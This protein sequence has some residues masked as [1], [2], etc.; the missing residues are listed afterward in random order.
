MPKYNYPFIKPSTIKGLGGYS[1]N[2]QAP[3]SDL[4]D[5]GITSTTVNISINSLFRSEPSKDNIPFEYLGKTY[6][7]NK[8]ALE[9]YD[10]TLISTAKRNIEVSAILLVGKAEQSPDKTIGEILQHP[11]CDPAVRAG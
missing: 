3:I 5:L 4:D 7:V 9:D 6:Y 10:K 11:D 2:R 8:K 1:S